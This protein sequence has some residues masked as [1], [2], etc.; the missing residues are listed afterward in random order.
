MKKIALLSALA[1]A[2]L[3]AP[4][5]SAQDA[6]AEIEASVPELEALISLPQQARLAREADEDLASPRNLF[7]SEAVR[8]ALLGD[9]PKFIYIPEGTDPM[10]IPWV[11]ATI[12]AAELYADAE[13]IFLE[14]ASR[15]DQEAAKRAL[16]KLE[17]I[18]DNYAEAAD[19]GKA[20]ALLARVEEF[21]DRDP[22]DKNQTV[23]EVPVAPIGTGELPQWITTNTTGILLDLDTPTES[24]IVVGDYL[25]SQGDIVARYPDVSVKEIRDQ[26][27]VFEYQGRDYIV[28]V[29]TQ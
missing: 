19:A 8:R 16:P 5:A 10:I 1:A 7:E 3:A 12:V 27:V 28:Q 11:R 14:A 15:G 2:M 22:S 23:V 13:K 29:K 18:R 26:Q 6:E 21:L 9:D 17:G 4:D 20:Q 24:L 25:L